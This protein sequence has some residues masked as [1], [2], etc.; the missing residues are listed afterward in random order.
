MSSGSD[1]SDTPRELGNTESSRD[2]AC[3]Q[4]FFTWN[5]YTDDDINSILIHTLIQLYLFQKEISKSGT[6]HLQGV[7]T[8]KKKERLSWWKNN[9]PRMHVEKVKNY[10]ASSDYCTKIDTAVPDS[11]YTNWYYPE[12]YHI[13]EFRWWQKKLNAIIAQKP[14]PR[15]LYWIWSEMGKTGKSTYAKW[16]VHHKGALVLR[17]K[18]ADM[19][20][21]IIK[22]REEYGDPY[23]IIID[24]PRSKSLDEI[25][26][27]ALEDIKNGCF[28]SGKYEG[29]MVVMAKPHILIFS[30]HEPNKKELSEDRWEDSII[31]IDPVPE[32]DEIWFP[33]KKSSR[34]NDENDNEYA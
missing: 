22:Y 2:S 13:G 32:P 11:V 9:F 14:D 25:N 7:I 6:P 3:K 24:I 30:N 10:V 29:G 21:G 4:W 15:K 33:T 34:H 5:N 20:H 8:L 18:E 1:V 27:T 12:D 31:C 26:Y 28:F 16:L 19:K 23:L 17:G